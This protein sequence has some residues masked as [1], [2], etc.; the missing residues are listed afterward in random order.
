MATGW[1][2]PVGYR[3][4][5][6]VMSE[7]KA[8]CSKTHECRKAKHGVNRRHVIALLGVLNAL[9]GVASAEPPKQFRRLGVLNTLDEHDPVW[10]SMHFAFLQDLQ[11]LGWTEGS[12]LEINYRH[13]AGENLD[14][15]RTHA[16]ELVA[17]NSDVLVTGT[18]IGVKALQQARHSAPIVF[19]WVVNPV[20]RGIVDSLA[21]PGHG[22]TGFTGWEPAIGGRWV[23][24]LKEVAP[25]VARIGAVHHPNNPLWA[26]AMQTVERAGFQLG[27][28]VSSI[29]VTDAT[30][31]EHRLES[32]ARR[33][34][35]GLIV[36]PEPITASHKDLIVTLASRFALPAIYGAKWFPF[37]GGLMSYG[38]DYIDVG[39]RAASYVDRVLRG[40]DP[41]KLPV[42]QPTKF[43][44]VINLKT[45]NTLGLNVPSTLLAQADE[46]IE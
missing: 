43:E 24:M 11:Q 22:T 17:L 20:E 31:I 39:R 18:T 10:Q 1:S 21:H 32:F 27:I 46:V 2:S 7:P 38:V 25:A 28:D 19:Y 34:A 9:S 37:S 42:Q 29:D 26:E 30:E 13:G 40:D 14:R 15:V 5:Y 35:G 33:S 36:L 3:G 8:M 4:D 44:L 6:P 12:N 23:Q 16:A 41:D 45:A